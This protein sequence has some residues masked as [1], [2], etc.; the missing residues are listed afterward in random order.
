MRGL[1]IKPNEITFVGILT[2][3]SHI[4]MVEEGL[5]LYRTMLEEYGISPTKEHC[6]C[7]VDLLARAGC[8]DEAEDFIKQIP[9]D[10]DIVVWKT[11]L[12]ACKVHGNLE[13]GKRAAENVLKIDPSNSAALVMLCNIH[14]SSG[15]WKDFAQLRS[16]MRQMN[17]SKIPGQSWIEIKDKVHVFLAE[18]SLHPERGKIYTMLEELMCQILD[19]GRDPMQ[20]TK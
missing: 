12:A 16:S 17:V 2:A 13:V 11:L 18:D 15:R 19:D 10:P 1:D 7:M 5:K 9:F 14:A 8:L 3:C 6:S 20:V 4:G